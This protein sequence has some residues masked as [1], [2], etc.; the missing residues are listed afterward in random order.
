VF[1]YVENG[2]GWSLGKVGGNFL[3]INS[4]ISPCLVD[5]SVVR[6]M[7]NKVERHPCMDLLLLFLIIII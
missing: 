1:I 3:V 6:V 7:L 4:V 5:R 2:M